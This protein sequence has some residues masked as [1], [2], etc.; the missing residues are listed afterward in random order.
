[1][2][3]PDFHKDDWGN[4]IELVVRDRSTSRPLDI[5]DVDNLW[6]WFQPPS[7]AANAFEKTAAFSTDGTDGRMRYVWEEGD[8]SEVGQ[9]NTQ[10]FLEDASG[11]WHTDIEIFQVGE[12]VV[13]P[14]PVP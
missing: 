4:V 2:S 6:M 5:S 10:G 13:I 11:E 8:L 7:G 9:W 1:M 12:N 14:T 3:D